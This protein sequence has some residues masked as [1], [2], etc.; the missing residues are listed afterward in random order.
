MINPSKVGGNRQIRLKHSAKRE[1]L[2]V[3]ERARL[4]VA[5]RRQ[6]SGAEDRAVGDD[7][8]R[9]TDDAWTHTPSTRGTSFEEN[10][11]PRRHTSSCRMNFSLK[12]FPVST[13]LRTLNGDHRNRASRWKFMDT[14]FKE[15]IEEMYLQDVFSWGINPRI[16]LSN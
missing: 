16:Q 12:S 10:E 14:I 7:E 4:M 15:I 8:Q 1:T 11:F 3:R 2:R 9:G 5:H 13:W 6:R